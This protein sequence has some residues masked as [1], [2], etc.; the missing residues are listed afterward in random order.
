MIH[1]LRKLSDGWTDGRKDGRTDNQDGQTDESDFTGRCPT[2]VKCP[3]IM[4]HL[5]IR[6][7]ESF[8]FRIK[9][10]TQHAIPV[11]IQ[12]QNHQGDVLNLSIL[13]NFLAILHFYTP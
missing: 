9:N 7:N 4:N 11:E 5:T 6:N 8:F 12:Q 1:S 13:T 10:I 3:E 2:N